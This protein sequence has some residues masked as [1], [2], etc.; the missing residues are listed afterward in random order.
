VGDSDEEDD[1]SDEGLRARLLFLRLPRAS[2]SLSEDRVLASAPPA[3]E[4][5]W[6]WGISSCG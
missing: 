2:S 5:G 4:D 3:V 6:S 1:E